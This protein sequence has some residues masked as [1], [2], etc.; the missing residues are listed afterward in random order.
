MQQSSR[1]S[2]LNVK[3]LTPADGVI[4]VGGAVHSSGTQ[5]DERTMYAPSGNLSGQTI[6]ITAAQ[7]L[8]GHLHVTNATNSNALFYFPSA[9][10]IVGYYTDAGRPLQVGDEFTFLVSRG[11]TGIGSVL[12][13][14]S[15][16]DSVIYANGADNV[17]TPCGW[18]TLFTLRVTAVGTAPHITVYYLRGEEYMRH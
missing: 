4:E 17:Q 7:F 6:T 5:L 8:G 18:M 13:Y 3:R 2:I 9:S 12:V 11:W 10:D 1:H 15:L 14:H 16:D